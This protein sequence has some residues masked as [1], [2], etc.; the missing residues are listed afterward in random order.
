MGAT[1]ADPALTAMADALLWTDQQT[2]E[3]ANQHQVRKARRL[4]AT[5]ER[6]G[7]GRGSRTKTCG[8]S[9]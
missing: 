4:Q 2:R 5:T 7:G 6:P 8:A 1:P 3:V 9:R